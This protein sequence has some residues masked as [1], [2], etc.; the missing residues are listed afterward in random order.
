MQGLRDEE[1]MMEYQRG[2]LLAMGEL[3]RRYKNP[4]FSFAYRFLGD[5]EEAREIAQEVFLRLHIHKAS[6]RPA[7]KFS[8]WIFSICHNL[9]VSTIR[10]RRRFVLWPRKS[11]EDDGYVDIA[12]NAPSPDTSVSENDLQQT[13]KHCIDSLPF[14]QKEALVLR[15]YQSMSYEDIAAAMKQPLNTVKSLVHR[16]RISLKEKL[17]PLVN[18]GKRGQSC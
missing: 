18:E 14:L 4:V 17:L 9:C 5:R 6:Y 16:A 7:G 11:K 13:I 8:T 10:R 15:E 2:N 12:D 1:V 3:L